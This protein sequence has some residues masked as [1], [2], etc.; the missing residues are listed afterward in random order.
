MNWLA[1]VLLVLAVL[2]VL[3][4]QD[5]NFAND[6][7]NQVAACEGLCDG[8]NTVKKILESEKKKKK[9]RELIYSA[10]TVRWNLH[11]LLRHF[12]RHMQHTLWHI[13]CK[14]ASSPLFVVFAEHCFLSH[15][16][17]Q[18]AGISKPSRSAAQRAAQLV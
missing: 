10:F 15:F 12:F 7:A 3:Y 5:C 18:P 14:F 11:K 13:I 16:A 1:L 17:Q 4:A 9:K 2:P 6:C 8:G